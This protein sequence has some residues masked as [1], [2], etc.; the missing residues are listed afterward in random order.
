MDRWLVNLS[1][2]HASVELGS[3][4][5]LSCFLLGLESGRR[6]LRLIAVHLHL[7]V[8]VVEEAA[9]SATHV[10]LALV[11]RLLI[12]AAHGGFVSLTTGAKH[13]R[14]NG[15][16]GLLLILTAGGLLLFLHNLRATRV[17][18]H[19]L[20]LLVAVL[21]H[22]HV[23]LPRGERVLLLRAAESLVDRHRVVTRAH[24]TFRRLIGLLSSHRVVA[25]VNTGRRV[26][27]LAVVQVTA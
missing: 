9:E 13:R 5:T 1:A 3:H 25:A 24:G 4:A 8:A 22:S 17:T 15:H 2:E 16:D 20:M 23:G 11:T 14:R 7:L 27:H 6:L 26:H 12:H 21:R 18:S 19:L 10:L